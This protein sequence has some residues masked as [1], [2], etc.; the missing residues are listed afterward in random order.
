MIG[1][2]LRK[3]IQQMFLIFY[4]PK[5]KKYVELIFHIYNS[6]H[7]KQLILLMISIEEKEGC[8]YLSVKK[9]PTL[10]RGVTSKHNGDFYCLKCFHSFRTENELKSHEKVCKNKDFCGIAMLSEKGLNITVQTLYE[11]RKIPYIIY[12]DIGSLLKK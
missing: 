4:I 3:I 5:K 7:E 11:A 2:G 10:L 12:A 9:L 8:H 1:T 6:T